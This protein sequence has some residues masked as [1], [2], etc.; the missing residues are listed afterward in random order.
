MRLED[1]GAD[2]LMASNSYKQIQAFVKARRE[3]LFGNS[4]QLH[5]TYKKFSQLYLDEGH[6]LGTLHYGTVRQKGTAALLSTLS[7]STSALESNG[8]VDFLRYSVNKGAKRTQ[9]LQAS[10][11]SQ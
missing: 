9:R 3:G 10:E 8:V 11:Y 4:E 6:D 1:L 2:T 5:A 7:P